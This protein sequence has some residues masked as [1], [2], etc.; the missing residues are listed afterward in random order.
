MGASPNR[1]YLA[2]LLKIAFSNLFYLQVKPVFER[3]LEELEEKIDVMLSGLGTWAE[4]KLKSM[5]QSKSG[6]RL[7]T[8]CRP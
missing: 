6:K 2:L 4:E 1:I 7:Y 3:M 5:L 8:A